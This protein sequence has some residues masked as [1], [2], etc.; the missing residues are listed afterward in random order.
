MGHRRTT[1]PI[2]G[3]DAHPNAPEIRG[4]LSR[5][6]CVT[7]GELEALADAWHNTTLLA[8][9]RRRSLEP[10]SPLV[11]EV[12]TCFE[13]AQSLFAPEIHA[14]DLAGDDGFLTVDP[15]VVSTALKA[16][17]DA[18][19]AAYAQPILTPAEHGTLMKAWRS[20]YATDHV[21]D[22]D[23]GA[24]AA[25][26]ALLLDAIPRLAARC[27]D[28]TAAAEY[29]SILVASQD[30][31]ED[32]RCAAR[33]EAWNA[34]VLT[35]R[36]RI[37]QLVQCSGAEGLHRYC[38]VCRSRERDELTARVLGLCVDAACGLLVAGALDDDIVDV[39]VEPVQCLIPAQRP[40]AET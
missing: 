29:A 38:T 27:H 35:S 11:V 3:L 20:V 13:T 17:R 31:D 40:S 21:V 28:A 32:M 12:L 4:I 18:I 25:D 1:L 6:P 33:D 5:L 37:W 30:V 36:H 39:L 26:V 24:R 2:G 23:L 14:A 9:A 22:P 8:E 7:D 19:A 10:D 34:A 15:D 16:M